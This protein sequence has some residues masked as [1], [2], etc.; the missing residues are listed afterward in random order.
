LNKAIHR[1][2]YKRGNRSP[3]NENYLE[4][5][6]VVYTALIS[7]SDYVVAIAGIK[8]VNIVNVNDTLNKT[9]DIVSPLYFQFFNADL[10]AGWQHLHY[11]AINAIKA[12]ETGINISKNL[13]VETLLYSTGQDQI[14]AGFKLLGI[15]PSTKRVALIVLGNEKERTTEICERVI[16]EIG[17]PDDSVLMIDDK[18]FQ[19]LKEV[20]EINEIALNTLKGTKYEKITN[21]IIEKGALLALRR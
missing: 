1:F 8:D 6:L 20:F 5:M 4:V 16:R 3:K 14:I 7:D 2:L 15:S 10:I 9:Q 18:K 13:E 21:L 19:K 12:F 17:T 11:S